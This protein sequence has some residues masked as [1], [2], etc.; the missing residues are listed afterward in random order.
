MNKITGALL[1]EDGGV[2]KDKLQSLGANS[3]DLEYVFDSK[4]K[5]LSIVALDQLWHLPPRDLARQLLALLEP[6]HRL[7]QVAL[8]SIFE[9]GFNDHGPGHIAR[10]TM[11]TLAALEVAGMS[12]DEV[13]VGVLA[14]CC[15][16]LGNI[17]ERKTH[18]IWSGRMLLSIVSFGR[19][20]KLCKRVMEAIYYHEEQAHKEAG[21][22]ES[23][24]PSTVALILADKTDVSYLRVHPISDQRAAIDDEHVIINFMVDDTEIGFRQTKIVWRLTF[25]PNATRVQGIFSELLKHGERKLVP[26]EWQQMYRNENIEYMFIFYAKILSLYLDRIKLAIEAGFILFPQIDRFQFVVRDPERRIEIEREF[27]RQ[28]AAEQIDQLKRNLVK[29]NSE[30]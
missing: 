29:N 5:L 11:Q 12:D 9:T 3:D 23:L 6:H 7:Q 24:S 2:V 17:V 8:N 16:D 1:L 10:V 26:D 30:K 4:G 28:S 18:N 19:Q 25:N 22:L 20:E 14:A 15:H 13:K 21:G 27:L